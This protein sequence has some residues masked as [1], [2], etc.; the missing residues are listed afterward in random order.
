M[1]AIVTAQVGTPINAPS[2]AFSTGV[3]PAVDNPTPEHYFNTCY[4]DTSGNRQNCALDPEPAWIQ[5][6]PFT[7]STLPT[8]M[9]S[10]RL[11]TPTTLDLSF[12]KSFTLAGRARLQFR[13]EVFNLTNAVYRGAPNTALTS[14][15]FGQQSTAQ[16]NDP[17]AMQLALKFL[18]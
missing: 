12:F 15:A 14:P 16:I 9:S 17:R 10:V 8:R 4:I 7:L 3:D 6:P 1:N 5:Q 18:F 2:G 13:A 11:G